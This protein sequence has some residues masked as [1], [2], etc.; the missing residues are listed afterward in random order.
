MMGVEGPES[1]D[2]I[3]GNEDLY[4]EDRKKKRQRGEHDKVRLRSLFL[5]K[6]A[7]QGLS[8]ADTVQA[9]FVYFEDQGYIKKCPI[10]KQ[11]ALN[12]V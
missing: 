12:V 10:P 5:G 3:L 4:W 9:T 8:E 7:C 11:C 1:R 2:C 6:T